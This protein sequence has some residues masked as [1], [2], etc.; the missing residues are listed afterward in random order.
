[1]CTCRLH[2]CKP[3][4]LVCRYTQ[5]R[6]AA[7]AIRAG[8]YTLTNANDRQKYTTNFLRYCYYIKTTLKSWSKKAGRRSVRVQKSRRRHVNDIELRQRRAD[9]RISVCSP[10]IHPQ[11]SICRTACISADLSTVSKK[12][13]VYV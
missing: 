7:E 8:N 3:I 9:S 4:N 5:H 12:M 11:T 6:T 2:T 13:C 1:M 10:K